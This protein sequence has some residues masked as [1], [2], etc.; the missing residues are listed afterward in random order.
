M[1]IS[2]AVFSFIFFIFFNI[3]KSHAWVPVATFNVLFI[4][5]CFQLLLLLLLLLEEEEE[6]ETQ[7]SLG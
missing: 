6:E 2:Y 4:V 5:S 7:L 1:F 3:F